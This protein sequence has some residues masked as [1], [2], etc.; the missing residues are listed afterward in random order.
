MVNLNKIEW[1]Y[2]YYFTMDIVKKFKL[3][4][5]TRADGS[6]E[7][8]IEPVDEPICYLGCKFVGTIKNGKPL[9]GTLSNDGWSLV[10]EW[11]NAICKGTYNCAQCVM[12]GIFNFTDITNVTSVPD[13]CFTGKLTLKENCIIDKLHFCML[14]SGA[15]CI[16]AN[17][18]AIKGDADLNN[19]PSIVVH[20]E[21]SS[22]IKGTFL[23][24]AYSGN[25]TFI[26]GKF[27]YCN[28]SYEIDGSQLTIVGLNYSYNGGYV[29]DIDYR[30]AREY[31]RH[32]HGVEEFKNVKYSGNWVN[33]EKNGPFQITANGKT[34]TLI[35]EDGEI[36]DFV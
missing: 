26:K 14:Q 16:T 19:Y 25:I 6:S 31:L 18:A 27:Q 35:Y 5:T 23:V 15:L 10:G 11:D 36:I 9:S 21:T 34:I 28:Q 4:I 3:T 7:T 32:G 24:D 33:D 20:G 29:N 22:M 1:L 13:K 8:K 12:E 30:L 17:S 2:F